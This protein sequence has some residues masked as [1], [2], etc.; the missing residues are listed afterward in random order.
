MAGIKDCY[1]SSRGRT[2]TMDNFITACFNALSKSYGFLEPT[3]WYNLPIL[4][5]PFDKYPGRADDLDAHDDFEQ[6]VY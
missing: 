4:K 2:R 1:T 3:L 5:M 6:N